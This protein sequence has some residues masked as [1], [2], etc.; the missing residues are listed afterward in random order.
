[1]SLTVLCVPCSR[2]SY[3]CHICDCFMCAIFARQR[4]QSPCNGGVI[5]PTFIFILDGVMT[6]NIQHIPIND[7][8]LKECFIS[9]CKKTGIS[10]NVTSEP[11]ERFNLRD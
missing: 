11:L 1:M 10:F 9:F 4:L 7:T 3:V 6:E 2:L 5:T 8:C